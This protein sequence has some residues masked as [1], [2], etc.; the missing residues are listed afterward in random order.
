MTFIASS[1]AREGIEIAAQ[2]NPNLSA[3][4]RTGQS[5]F[6]SGML[7]EGDA[8]KGDGAAQTRDILKRL[9]VVLAK[10]GFARTDVR[11]LLVYVTDDEA[12]AP[13][14]TECRSAF[15]A[16]TALTAVKAA[17]VQAGGRVEIMAFAEHG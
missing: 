11:E 10:A 1:A 16:R 17:L 9:D 14:M 2:P 13:A 3:A 7:A 6:V 8:L 4:V 5:L 15:G 12:A